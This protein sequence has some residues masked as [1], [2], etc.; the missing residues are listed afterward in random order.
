MN[1]LVLKDDCLIVI[2]MWCGFIFEI[3]GRGSDGEGFGFIFW[4][5][6][7]KIFGE[8]EREGVSEEDLSFFVW[9]L[10]FCDVCF[11]DVF[12]M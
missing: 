1:F 12:E 8:E 3:E 10:V 4:I 2:V 7:S 6:G 9:L 11:L 5:L